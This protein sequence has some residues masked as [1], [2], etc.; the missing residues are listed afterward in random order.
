[1][2]DAQTLYKLIVLSMLDKVD[3][4]LTNSQISAFILEQQYTDYFT[5]QETLSDMVRA[6]YLQ[7]D[8]IRNSTRYTMTEKG[9]ETLLYFGNEVSDGIKADIREYFKK[10]K[11]TMRNEN[12]VTADYRRVG[13]DYAVQLQVRERDT[14]LIDLTLTVPLEE[15]AA[16]MCD[17]WRKKSQEAYSYL[18]REL[19]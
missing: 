13:A 9:R 4:A 3:F 12:A 5:V 8:V 16:A 6:G 15:Q 2:S 11:L 7:S 10:N 1:M 14:I 18:M 17:N 19:L